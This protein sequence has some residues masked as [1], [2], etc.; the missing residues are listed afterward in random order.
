MILR[1]GVGGVSW[2]V[3]GYGCR[4]RCI[5][6]FIRR[7]RHLLFLLVL[8]VIRGFFAINRSDIGSICSMGLVA[9][10]EAIS[11]FDL[12]SPKFNYS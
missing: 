11:I 9:S 4:D 8:G 1:V 7:N 5:F 2:I 12:I 3:R 6:L 10:R